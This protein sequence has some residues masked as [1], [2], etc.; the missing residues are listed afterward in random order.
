MHTN[1]TLPRPSAHKTLKLHERSGQIRW[2]LLFA[3]P[4]RL[5]RQ[6]QRLQQQLADW[7]ARGKISRRYK[8]FTSPPELF[9]IGAYLGV[10]PHNRRLG[11]RGKLRR[12]CLRRREQGHGASRYL[13]RSALGVA[14]REK[15]AKRGC[16]D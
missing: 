9:K 7:R 13:Q 15:T 5:Q 6:W 1:L 4:I 11:E 12:G 3:R 14:V 10:E 16:Y 2:R 8:N